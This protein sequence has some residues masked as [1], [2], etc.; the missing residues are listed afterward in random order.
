MNMK[1]ISGGAVSDDLKIATL[2]AWLGFGCEE[3]R[4]AGTRQ[5]DVHGL[6]CDVFFGWGCWGGVASR[7]QLNADTLL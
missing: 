3:G 4:A 2:L 7:R 1:L 5:G 6:F